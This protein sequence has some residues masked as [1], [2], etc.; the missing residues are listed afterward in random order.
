[1]EGDD[2]PLLLGKKIARLALPFPSRGSSRPGATSGHENCAGD[3]TEGGYFQVSRP[4][5]S[6]AQ[7]KAYS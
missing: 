1:M 4:Q 5:P 2:R 3:T 7:G 6:R